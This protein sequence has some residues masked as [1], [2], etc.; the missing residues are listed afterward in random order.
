[1]DRKF[2]LEITC[3]PSVDRMGQQGA[4]M[5]K[6]ILSILLSTVATAAHADDYWSGF[7]DINT[8]FQR[9]SYYNGSNVKV[10]QDD[11]WHRTATAE[12]QYRWNA[13]AIGARANFSVVSY[14][15]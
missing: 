14:D 9:D 3:P 11:Q 12:V 4:N 7:L 5:K 6:F 15:T 2:M 1:M 8:A 10:L 13:C